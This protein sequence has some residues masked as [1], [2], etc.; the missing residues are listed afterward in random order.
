ML[1]MVTVFQFLSPVNV[2][3]SVFSNVQ[4]QRYASIFLLPALQYSYNLLSTIIKHHFNIL[5]IILQHNL[6]NV[7]A[8]IQHNPNHVLHNYTVPS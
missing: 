5:G 8:F 7:C 6:N 1:D 3:E 2:N 4:V